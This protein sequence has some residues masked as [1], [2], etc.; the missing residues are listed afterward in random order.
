MALAT[1]WAVGLLV[2]VAPDADGPDY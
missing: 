1:G 2:F